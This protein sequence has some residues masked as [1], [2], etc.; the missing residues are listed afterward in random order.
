MYIKKSIAILIIIFIFVQNKKAQTLLPFVSDN[1]CLDELIRVNTFSLSIQ[2]SK[3]LLVAN[4]D[5]SGAKEV[6]VAN[7]NLNTIKIYSFS[8]AAGSFTFQAAISPLGDFSNSKF[9]AIDEGNFNNDGLQDL[10]YTTDSFI[11][12]LKNGI[13]FNFTL[14]NNQKIPIPSNYI[15]KN[16]YLK[17]DDIDGNG[18]QD[19]YFISYTSIGPGLRIHPFLNFGTTFAAQG[20]IVVFPTTNISSTTAI[21]ISIG[22]IKGNG[23]N[24]LDV[25]ITCSAQPDEIYFLENNTI[26]SAIFSVITKSLTPPFPFTT[27]YFTIT[28]SELSDLNNDG[29]PD[30]ILSGKIN[31]TTNQIS[32]LPSLSNFIFGTNITLSSSGVEINDFKIKDITSDGVK[33]FVAIGNYASLTAGMF[34]MPGDANLSNYFNQT[35]SVI[36][37]ISNTIK[38]NEMELVDVDNN[39]INDIVMKPSGYN[40]DFTYMI[41]NYTH[42]VNA[43]GSPTLICGNTIANISVS[44]NPI[45]SLVLKY[46][47]EN[48]N[49][50]SIVATSSN[51]TT[52]IADKYKLLVDFNMYS[53]KTCTLKSDT[54]DIKTNTLLLTLSPPKVTDCYGN[55]V[56]TTVSGASTYSWLS[57]GG[58]NSILS[59]SS[60]FTTQ[61]LSNTQFTVIGAD[62]NGCKGNNTIDINLYPLNTNSIETTGNNICVGDSVTLS[63]MGATSYTWSHG[64]FNGYG[65]YINVTPSA[66]TTYSLTFKD[67][68]SCISFKTIDITINENCGDQNINA[69]TPNG[70]GINDF[71]YIENIDR[72]KNVS[73][74]IYGRWGQEIFT[75]EKYNNTT[76]YWPKK[77][78]T[79]NL[80]ST[81][82]FYVINYSNGEIK[83]GWIEVLKD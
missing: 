79:N 46:S 1:I 62:A 24:K 70:D 61:I 39:G 67:A 15:G 27:P 37:F 48:T 57:S 10:I 65:S 83:K 5:N 44:L 66:N 41:P 53:N 74:T 42:K 4:L 16:H 11:Y 19:F 80:I 25:M 38:P 30:V 28:S 59:T 73:V 50:G 45:S 22:D 6:V 8:P 12:V 31:T 77:E 60:I 55:I 36:T 64:S 7:G 43:A 63:F 51:F 13:G 18:L 17:L 76:S 75:S 29:K 58:T 23:D 69:I 14:L 68:N 54:V 34:I 3:N 35:L 82:Y 56:T 20:S 49:T 9:E 32:I 33:D 26:T 40:S 21:D 72:Y 52:T 47:W 2:N 71:F 81:T 78:E